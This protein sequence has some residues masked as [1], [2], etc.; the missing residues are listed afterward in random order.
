MNMLVIGSGI[1]GLSTA[2]LL[3]RDGHEVTVVERDCDA[4]PVSPPTAWDDWQRRQWS[5]A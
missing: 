1:C 5:R 3:A 2:L 4:Q